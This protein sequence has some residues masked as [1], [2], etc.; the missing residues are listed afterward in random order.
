MPVKALEFGTRL[1]GPG[2]KE[3]VV[4]GPPSGTLMIDSPEIGRAAFAQKGGCLLRLTPSAIL[5]SNRTGHLVF[6]FIFHLRLFMFG[7]VLILLQHRVEAQPILATEYLGIVYPIAPI[8]S[9]WRDWCGGD[10][11]FWDSGLHPHI[12]SL[13]QANE[14]QRTAVENPSGTILSIL[15][16][17]T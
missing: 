1:N 2:A 11:I 7:P 3:N 13:C 6:Q 16:S 15:E 17:Y 5:F 4:G 10:E 14:T 8:A 9:L 12:T